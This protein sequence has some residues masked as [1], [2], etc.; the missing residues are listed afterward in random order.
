MIIR[1]GGGEK[2]PKRKK[3]SILPDYIGLPQDSDN[4]IVQKSNPLQSLSE[5]GMTL[6]EFKILDAYLSRIDSHDEDK[7]YVR[8]AKGELEKLL[9]VD[10]IRKE[11]LSKRLEGLFQVVTIK[12]ENKREGFSKIALFEKAE[13]T[14]D[15]KGLW[16]VDLACT[17][18]AM[19]Y[20]F[21]IE[22][23]HYLQYRLKNVINLKSRY[24]Y[25]LYMY[26]ENNRFRKT[27]KIMLDNLKNMLQCTG[28]T[29][30]EY[31]EF[32]QKILKKCQQEINAQTTLTFSYSP[33][34]KQ[35]RKY[36]S[37]E[38]T[39]EEVRDLFENNDQQSYSP[40]SVIETKSDTGVGGKI[41]QLSFADD[42]EY[43]EEN[44]EKQEIDYGGELADLLGNVSCED[45]FSPQQIRVIQ[46]LVLKALGSGQDHITY[47]DYL[48]NKVHMMNLYQPKNR[49][50]YLVKMIKNDI[51]E[52]EA[53]W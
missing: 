27:W 3:L 7:R 15:E 29:Y 47:C 44:Q 22:N 49:Y 11:D 28:E 1:S 37:I 16:Q 13:A 42:E 51:K 8:F 52:Q 12:D 10:R 39:I 53:V 19:E 17:Q 18:S 20:V 23:L 34:D 2:M 5:S 48:T 25:I 26:L 50:S 41:K 6:S 33:K 21:N 40:V 46:D 38:F 30:K 9:G 43:P 36:V 45:E 14:Q 32:N 24:S 35:G 31:K 4:M